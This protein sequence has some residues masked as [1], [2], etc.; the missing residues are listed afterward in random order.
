MIKLIFLEFNEQHNPKL[1]ITKLSIEYL[2]QK[3][4][5]KLLFLMNLE[6]CVINLLSIKFCK[7][8]LDMNEISSPRLNLL[9]CDRTFHSGP[10]GKRFR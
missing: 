8:F 7:F 2:E 6:I 5:Y 4:C 3:T 9:R 10:F 1:A